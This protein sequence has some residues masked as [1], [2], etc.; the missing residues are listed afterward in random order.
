MTSAGSRPRPELHPNAVRVLLEGF[1]IDITGQQPRHLDTLG[2]RRFQ[3][4]I[5][6]CD[7]ARESCP[8][9]GHHPRRAHWSIP[10]P[11][12]AGDADQLSYPAFQRTAAELDRRIRH[13]LPVL[14]STR[15]L[16]EVQP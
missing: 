14:A 12:Q 6:L 3:H 1:G 9:F 15:P 10:D 7:K 16:E 13:L 4:V 11:A 5:T 2:G 8:E